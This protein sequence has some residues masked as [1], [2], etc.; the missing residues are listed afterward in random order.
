M[1]YF[2]KNISAVAELSP[3]SVWQ[4]LTGPSPNK[5]GECC[6]N[7]YRRIGD[8]CPPPPPRKLIQHQADI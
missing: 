6:Q 2:Y 7:I 5:A 1:M 8:Q 4:L 3:V